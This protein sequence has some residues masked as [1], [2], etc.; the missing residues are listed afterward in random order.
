MCVIWEGGADSALRGLRA[1]LTAR[2]RRKMSRRGIT[3]GQLR[4]ITHM[5]N[6]H[7]EIAF[8]EKN[9]VGNLK[10]EDADGNYIGF[11]DL[12]TGGLVMFSDDDYPEP[13]S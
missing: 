10:C 2:R 8:L 12:A 5:V 1:V 11:A 7:P 6:L 4:A 13:V 9:I 3:P